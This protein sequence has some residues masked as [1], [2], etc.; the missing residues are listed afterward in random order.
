MACSRK[1][2]TMTLC[3]GKTRTTD[4]ARDCK[5]DACKQ[6]WAVNVPGYFLCPQCNDV[7]LVGSDGP[8]S[9]GICESCFDESFDDDE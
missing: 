4:I 7:C 8:Y 5:C 9:G 1:V 2:F 6:W 3:E